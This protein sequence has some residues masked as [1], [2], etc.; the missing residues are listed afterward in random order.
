MSLAQAV[1]M[2]RGKVGTY[3]TL[4]LADPTMHHT[5]AFVLKRGKLV[6]ERLRLE[7]IDP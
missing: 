5:N 2:V 6:H 4:D 1:S 7:V 3:V